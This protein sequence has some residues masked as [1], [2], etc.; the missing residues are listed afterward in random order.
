[1]SYECALA[2]VMEYIAGRLEVSEA[3]AVYTEQTIES[4]CSSSLV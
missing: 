1:M 4:P 3:G 2:Q